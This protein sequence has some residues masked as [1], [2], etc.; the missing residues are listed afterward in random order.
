MPAAPKKWCSI[1]IIFIVVLIC[2]TV[3]LLYTDKSTSKAPVH[4][5]YQTVKKKKE[6]GKMEKKCRAIV[7]SIFNKSFPSVRPSWLRNPRTNKRLEIDMFN[8]NI[9]TPIG[10]GLGFEYDGVQH[11]QYTPFYH[12][13]GPHEFV[14]QCKRDRHKDKV[15]KEK[16]VLLI[17]IPS[18]VVEGSLEPFIRSKLK[19]RGML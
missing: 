17:R 13:K 7:E 9:R 4:T 11:S 8:A 2:I 14:D 12:R 1:Q 5:K 15:C 18:Y 3:Y 10:K 19:E 16:G 6:T